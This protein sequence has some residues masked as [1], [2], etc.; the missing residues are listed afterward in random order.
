MDSYNYFDIYVFHNQ[1]INLVL[2]RIRMWLLADRLAMAWHLLTHYRR[3]YWHLCQLGYLDLTTT[4]Q[5][6]D[7]QSA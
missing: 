5:L 6:L 1:K 3:I 2:S 7:I 4:K